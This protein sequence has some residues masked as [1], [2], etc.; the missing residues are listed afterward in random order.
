MWSFQFLAKIKW[1]I[2]LNVRVDQLCCFLQTPHQVL[3][4]LFFFGLCVY[5]LESFQLT[6]KLDSYACICFLKASFLVVPESLSCSSL[7]DQIKDSKILDCHIHPDS[8]KNIGLS[9]SSR[10]KEINH[11][12]V[13]AISCYRW[14]LI[15]WMINLNSV[16]HMQVHKV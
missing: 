1:D 10:F 5:I 11:G 6:N 3:T 2:F 16:S 15:Q 9:H 8:K 7:L 14:P 4:I 12:S 13:L